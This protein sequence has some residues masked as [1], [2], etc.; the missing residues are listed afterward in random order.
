MSS[1]DIIWPIFDARL[2]SPE[3]FDPLGIIQSVKFKT[4]II[5]LEKS[6]GSVQETLRWVMDYYRA[7][8][9]IRQID[10]KLPKIWIL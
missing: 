7:G 2:P 4:I 6:V 9:M 8:A 5:S 1:I 10:L 3:F